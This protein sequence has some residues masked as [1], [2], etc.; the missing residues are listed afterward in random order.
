VIAMSVLVW[1]Q[2]RA[3]GAAAL[4]LLAAFA[5]LLVVTGVQMAAQ[6][7]T[8]LAA[9]TASRTCGGLENRLFLGSHAVGFLV[10]LTLIVPPVLGALCGTPLVARELET[11]TT[12]YV[13]TQAIT[14]RRWLAVKSSW[15]LLAAACAGAVIS[16]LVTWWSGPDNALQGD[17]F[18]FGRFDIMGV[19]PVAYAVF[20]VALGIACG[21]MLGRTVPAI[22]LTL[23]C[24]LAVR[25]FIAQALRPHFLAAVTHVYGL[26]QNY[27][28][29]GA[30][31]QI[32]AGTVT[33]SGQLVGMT[34]GTDIAPN[35]SASLVPA[36]CAGSQRA[37]LSCMQSAGYRQFVTF[38]PAS[39][40]WA[41]QGIEA[42]IFVVL[43]AALIAVTFVVVSR[44][45]V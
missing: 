23:A 28:P 19:V 42:G 26:M 37:V 8:A 9:C 18:A 30:A 10:I 43:A 35:V 25:L 34:N 6:W 38:Q 22:G 7:H 45:D 33:P 40:Y 5:A 31:W 13:W 4:G 24:Y 2:Y 17:E 36:S 27:T 32:A 1:R 12:Q 3:Q 11:G 44:R 20:A 41:F 15:L 39:R 21:A 14:R 16:G 29:P